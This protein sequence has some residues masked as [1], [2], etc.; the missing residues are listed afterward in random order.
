MGTATQKSGI[1][2]D[3]PELSFTNQCNL[4]GVSRSVVYYQAVEPSAEDTLLRH[5][6]DEI[7][8]RWPFCGSRKI[9]SILRLEGS[10]GEGIVSGR[11]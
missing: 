10:A 4:A 7:H 3:D 9:V 5:R 8:T 2:K 6:I 11:R 1:L